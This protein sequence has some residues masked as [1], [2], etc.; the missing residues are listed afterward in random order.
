MRGCCWPREL[1]R[2]SDTCRLLYC[3]DVMRRRGAK[4]AR[5]RALVLFPS[6]ARAGD[7]RKAPVAS[8]SLAVHLQASRLI[9]IQE[10]TTQHLC[11]RHTHRIKSEASRISAITNSSILVRAALAAARKQCARSSTS[12]PSFHHVGHPRRSCPATTVRP[13]A[14]QPAQTLAAFHQHPSLA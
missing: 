8:R 11:P 3:Y 7:D 1:Y 4:P 5:G 2:V 9:T 12:S 10:L 6:A 13:L 14:L